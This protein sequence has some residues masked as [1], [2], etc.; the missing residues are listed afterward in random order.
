MKA[1]LAAYQDSLSITK[2]LA[3]DDPKKV[4]IQRDLSLGHQNVGHILK[5]EDP[6]AALDHYRRSLTIADQLAA[7]D[8][9]NIELQRDVLQGHDRIGDVLEK[10]GHIPEAIAAYHKS[11]AI[12]ERL[13]DAEP[14]NDEWR[15]LS[16]RQSGRVQEL[17]GHR[18]EARDMYCRA[19]SMV[20][21]ELRQGEPQGQKRL[22]WLEERLAVVTGSS[23]SPC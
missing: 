2:R 11:L 20:Q 13:A 4:D 17:K 15:Y 14:T 19:K 1:A 10:L 21:S 16:Y 8:P 7:G 23:A 18:E 3:D 12:A 5:Q 22:H 6:Q 9:T